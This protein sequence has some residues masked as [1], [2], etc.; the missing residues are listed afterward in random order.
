MVRKYLAMILCVIG[1]HGF[2]ADISGNPGL[3]EL[4][5]SNAPVHRLSTLFT[6]HDVKNKLSSAEGLDK[7]IDWSKRTGLTKVYVE[8]FRDGYQA[9][10]EALQNAGKH[11]ESAGFEVSGCVTTTGIGKKS[12]KYKTVSCY[13]DLPT[14]AKL[15]A[16]F[17]Y[18]A[19]LF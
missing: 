3:W 9:E 15:Q 1:W 2:G 11:F 18:A 19:G 4:A 10:R 7:A 14:Q 12:S 5:R 13:T 17:E 6:A 8:C 16:I